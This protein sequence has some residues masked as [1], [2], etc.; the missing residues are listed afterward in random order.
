MTD[1]RVDHDKAQLV[2]L[3][4]LRAYL[5]ALLEAREAE[6]GIG[7]SRPKLELVSGRPLT[8]PLRS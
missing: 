4:S 2:W 6:L 7:P 8:G 5:Q 1:T 3:M